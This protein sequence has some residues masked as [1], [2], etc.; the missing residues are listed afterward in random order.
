MGAKFSLA[1]CRPSPQGA[2]L[3]LQV[4]ALPGTSDPEVFFFDPF[5][6]LKTGDFVVSRA[7]FI[8]HIHTVV[9]HGCLDAAAFQE[10]FP[11][12]SI[13]Y[14]SSLPKGHIIKGQGFLDTQRATLCTAK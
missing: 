1:K 4:S 8:H 9:Y 14:L 3:I 5:A 11:S 13:R 10:L 6:D 7:F 2:L 12:A